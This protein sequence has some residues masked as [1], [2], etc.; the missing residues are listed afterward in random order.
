MTVSPTLN[1]PNAS[2]L[3]NGVRVGSGAAS[4]PIPL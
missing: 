1:D 4:P 2:V 3:V